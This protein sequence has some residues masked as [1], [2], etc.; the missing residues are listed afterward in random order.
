MSSLLE[1]P[2]PSEIVVIEFIEGDT[3]AFRGSCSPGREHAYVEAVVEQF[4]IIY[5]VVRGSLIKW[6][7]KGN[8]YTPKKILEY[9]IDA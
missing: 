1:Q 8:V 3:I 6:E 5:S 2:S 9:L 4:G 7:T